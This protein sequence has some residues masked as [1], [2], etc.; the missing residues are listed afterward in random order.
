MLVIDSYEKNKT[1]HA[2]TLISM[3]HDPCLLA[4]ENAIAKYLKQNL[5]FWMKLDMGIG[6]NIVH[7]FINQIL[8][9]K[10]DVRK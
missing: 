4:I 5:L 2:H 9:Y 10:C 7:V 1:T 3:I 6:N 8:Q